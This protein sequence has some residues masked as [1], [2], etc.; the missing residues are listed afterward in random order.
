[1]SSSACSRFLSVI[2]FVNVCYALCM[3]AEPTASQ[4][5]DV[6]DYIVDLAQDA[7]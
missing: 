1:M 3:C 4:C 2:Y 7:L 6:K 5:P